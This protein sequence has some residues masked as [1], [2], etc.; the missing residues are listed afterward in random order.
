MKIENEKNGR[1][2]RLRKFWDFFITLELRSLA[3][4]IEL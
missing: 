4:M 2:K 3:R 1:E